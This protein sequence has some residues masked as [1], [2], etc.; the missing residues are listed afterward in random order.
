MET[1]LEGSYSHLFPQFQKQDPQTITFTPFSGPQPQPIKYRD[2]FVV[3]NLPIST[4]C[5]ITWPPSSEKGFE[6]SSTEIRLGQ[7]DG[8]LMIISLVPEKQD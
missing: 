1:L 5:K 4:I 8:K 7:K 6:L 2:T 3:P